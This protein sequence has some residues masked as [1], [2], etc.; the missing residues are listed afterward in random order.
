MASQ[1]TSG[2]TLLG[3]HLFEAGESRMIVASQIGPVS[4]SFAMGNLLAKGAT[5]A[6]LVI[7]GDQDVHVPLSGT[8]LFEGRPQRTQ[9]HV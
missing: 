3:A 6:M 9:S 2:R 7:N 8:Q 4:E 1:R 5:C